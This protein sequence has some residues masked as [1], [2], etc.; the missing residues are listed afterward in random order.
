M[1]AVKK[2]Y[3]VIGERQMPFLQILHGSEGYIQAIWRKTIKY[4]IYS[5]NMQIKRQFRK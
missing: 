2:Q 4:L 5:I 3:R 1:F